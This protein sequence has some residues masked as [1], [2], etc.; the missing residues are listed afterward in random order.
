MAMA[1]AA[2][3]GCPSRSCS[4]SLSCLRH[5]K[6]TSSAVEDYAV[7]AEHTKESG[8]EPWARKGHNEPLGCFLQ[9]QRQFF[10]ELLCHLKDQR[11]VFGSIREELGLPKSKLELR[12][13][14]I[15]NTMG[16]S[17][18]ISSCLNDYN[19]R[20]EVAMKPVSTASYIYAENL[21][22][23]QFEKSSDLGSG[24]ISENSSVSGAPV[25]VP[26]EESKEDDP[27]AMKEVAGTKNFQHP[28]WPEWTEFLNHLRPYA[29]N[30]KSKED[31]ELFEDTT[32]LKRAIVKFAQAHEG[33][34]R[35]LSR[36]DLL[37]LVEQE[38]PSMDE[39]TAAGKKKLQSYLKTDSSRLSSKVWS[40]KVPRA[41][42]TDVVRLLYRAVRSMPALGGAL[43]SDLNSAVIHIL[44]D[45]NSASNAQRNSATPTPENLPAAT[46]QP[47][48]DF[49]Q[50]TDS[51][52]VDKDEDGSST[53]NGEAS[54]H[55][56]NASIEQNGSSL[57]A[58]L[59]SSFLDL[60]RFGSLK[61]RV[62]A[63]R[64]R[65]ARESEAKEAAMFQMP[66]PFLTKE[67]DSSPMKK[68]IN[69]VARTKDKC[70]VTR[71]FE[72]L[73]A[74]IES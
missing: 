10:N 46:S 51:A 53:G 18:D 66:I 61:E 24:V 59:A 68:D 9:E 8:A 67:P 22:A 57:M 11:V 73:D 2:L 15:D 69:T 40:S 64:E 50:K 44:Q 45:L 49:N 54:P 65:L 14:A 28:S 60:P 43:P 47:T 1:R 52:K 63:R 3:T 62:D 30:E 29:S 5:S 16:L 6:F 12:K 71:N 39:K 55:E 32:I 37:M 48:Q 33:A 56:R 74:I 19:N 38:F 13:A 36:K 7:K 21:V 26:E 27:T 42:L 25:V 23:E 41:K 35:S 34:F 31:L 4:F 70:V 17:E 58:R 20:K 72:A